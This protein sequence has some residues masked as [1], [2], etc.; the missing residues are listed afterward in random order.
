[1][2]IPAGRLPVLVGGGQLNQRVA[3][4]TQ[5]LEPVDLMAEAVR[6]AEVDT[7]VTHLC[8]R[9]DSV[10]AVSTLSWRYRDPARLVADRVGAGDAQAVYTTGGGQTPQRLINLTAAEI[11]SGDVDLAVVC[12]AEAWRSRTRAKSAGVRPNWVVQPDHVEPDRM[13]GSELDMSHPAEWEQGLVL[14]TQGYA[15][16]ESAVR[17]AAGR[18]PDDHRD[19]IAALWSRFSE[20]AAGNPNAWSRQALSPAEVGTATAENRMIGWPYT[21]VMNANNSVDQAAAVIITSVDRAREL[22][23]AADRWVFLCGTGDGDEPYLSN[24]PDLHTAPAMDAAANRALEAAGVDASDVAHLDLYSCFPSAVQI[25][26]AALGV[27]L[28]RPLTVTGGL[29][30]AGGPWNNYPT[31]AIATMADVLRNDPGSYGLIWANGGFVGKHSVGVYSTR[32]PATLE[33]GPVAPPPPPSREVV[34]DHEGRVTIE[35]Y[36]VM[37]DRAGEREVGIAATLTDDGRRAWA[38]TRDADAM[39]AWCRQEWCGRPADRAAD[40]TLRLT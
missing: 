18:D 1:M 26:A 8:S 16:L 15:L 33:V 23:I 36:T 35:A 22:G 9:A 24:R 5:G 21:K 31:H 39:D 2:S 32:A 7:G 13:V 17:A 34:T 29:S 27:S 6:R 10:R 28:D 19:R 12:G 25:S 4:P 37:H 40:G 14:P 38:T 20:V 3:D 11:A 30:F